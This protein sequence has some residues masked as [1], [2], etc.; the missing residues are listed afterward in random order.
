MTLIFA[1]PEFPDRISLAQALCQEGLRHL[2]DA[3][4]LH[5]AVRFPASI[6]SSAKAAELVLK[7]VLVLDGAMGWWDKALST[8]TPLSDIENYLVLRR[9]FTEL[10]AYNP[11]LPADVKF[12]EKLTPS[13]S[14]A[15]GGGGN[16]P[17]QFNQLEENPEYPFLFYGLDPAAG[18]DTTQLRLPSQHFATTDSKKCYSIAHALTSAVMAQYPD[19]AAWKFSV[20]MPI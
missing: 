19:I 17:Q 7:S 13:R 20:P 5:N 3:R 11:T 8:H 10:Q 2:E 1:A 6:A 9:H 15:K 4:V 16:Q 18:T 12:L 14:T